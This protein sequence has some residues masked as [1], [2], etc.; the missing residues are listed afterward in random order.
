VPAI[1]EEGQALGT[2]RTSVEIASDW[3]GEEV[4]VLDAP[5]WRCGAEA[6]FFDCPPPP[7]TQKKRAVKKNRL[8]R[9]VAALDGVLNIPW[10]VCGG[11]GGRLQGCR[12]PESVVRGGACALKQVHAE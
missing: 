7:N 11:G 1:G 12:T 2:S 4:T 6:V 8:K 5:S 3:V 9:S 10:C